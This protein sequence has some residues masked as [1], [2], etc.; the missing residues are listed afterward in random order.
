MKLS[1]VS[2]TLAVVSAGMLSCGGY[3]G[4]SSSSYMPPSSNFAA[5]LSAANETPPGSTMGSGTL[6]LT[7]NGATMNYAV[8]ATGLSGNATGAHI[9]IG[10]VGQAG[11][12]VVD[13]AAITPPPAGTTTTFA[14]SFTAANIKNPTTPPLNPPVVTMDDL[15]ARSAPETPIS[16]SIPPPIP[17]ESPVGS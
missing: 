10:P 12:I 11:P 5:Q 2:A 16:T 17:V 9:H 4:S 7:L 13:F 6:S 3:S 8:Y 15:I 14:G 1:H